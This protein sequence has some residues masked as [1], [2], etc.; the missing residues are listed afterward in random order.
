M[1][2]PQFGHCQELVSGPQLLQRGWA[3]GAA[4]DLATGPKANCSPT[5]GEE[6]SVAGTNEA[7]RQDVQKEASQKGTA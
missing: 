3:G 1:V 4:Q 5:V 7:L 2:A 6:P